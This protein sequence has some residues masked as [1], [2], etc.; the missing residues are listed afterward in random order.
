MAIKGCG[1]LLAAAVLAGIAAT[2]TGIDAQATDADKVIAAARQALGGDGKID[3]V[4]TV[5]VVG[6]TTR[7]RPDGTSSE[8]EFELSI[9]LP[10]KYMRRDVLAAMGPTSVY[11]NTGFNGDGLINLTDV[12]PSL[13]A[14]GNIRVSMIGPGSAPPGVTLTPEQKADLDKRTIAGF[15]QEFT[16]L[17]L[18]MFISSFKAYP[19]QFKYGGQAESADGKADIL[20]V[21]GENGFTGRLFLDAATHLPLMFSWMDKEPLV[22]TV[23]GPGGGRGPTMTGGGGGRS[24]AAP[25]KEEME[26]MQQEMA[27][28]MKEAEAKRQTVE[29]RLFYADYK[30]YDGVKLPTRIQ[31]M[32][33]GKA[34][35]ETTF[36]RVKVNGKI[37]PKKFEPTK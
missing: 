12:P 5:S 37:D 25:T 11:R 14:G 2:G 4:K 35:Q 10:D 17:S 24:G 27:D 19:I 22:M 26:K 3:A 34:T 23:G 33:A 15:K 7:T 13:S 6:R 9:E 16:R 21:T 28:R 29:Y 8:S 32:V 18:G 20:D 30:T 31:Q 1:S 36:D